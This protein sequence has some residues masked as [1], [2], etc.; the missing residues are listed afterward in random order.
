MDMNEKNMHRRSEEQKA[1]KDE[2]VKKKKPVSCRG[3]LGGI[4][5]NETCSHFSKPW[6]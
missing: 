3:P 2:R 1:G 5:V 6:Y 4:V